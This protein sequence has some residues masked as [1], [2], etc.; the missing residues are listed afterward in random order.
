MKTCSRCKQIKEISAFKRN[1]DRFSSACKACS[2]A[3]AKVRYAQG[4]EA[5]RLLHRR[6]V[7]PVSGEIVK[8]CPVCL[9]EQA[10]SEYGPHPDRPRSYCRTCHAAKQRAAYQ[11]DPRP[12]REASKRYAERHPEAVK[13]R[14]Q[15][16]R[17]ANG[18]RIAVRQRRYNEC[19]RERRILYYREY[20][21]TRTPE[22][23]REI[24]K[25]ENERRQDY[26]RQ[27]AANHKE[28]LA[29]RARRHRHTHP[30]R[31]RESQHRR[32]AALLKSPVIER[33]DLRVIAWRDRYRCY[34]CGRALTRKQV[35]LDHVIPLSRGGAHTADNLKVACLSCNCRKGSRLLSELTLPFDPSP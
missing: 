21:A 34:L 27:Y 8:V 17:A 29:E 14:T 23:R 2:N 31:H 25:R 1:K 13:A 9:R 16:W 20:R 26:L 6:R 24:N 12:A 7:D 28:Q 4:K 5:V 10:I 33:V 18:D 32:R 15:K 19:N 22:E 35:T 3:A 11:A 30:E